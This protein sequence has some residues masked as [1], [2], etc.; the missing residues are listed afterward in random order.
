MN[1]KCVILKLQYFS[2]GLQF[3]SYIVKCRAVYLVATGSF[4]VNIFGK[5]LN[6]S[7]VHLYEKKHRVVFIRIINICFSL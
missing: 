4:S 1:I 3:N 7:N 2:K 6:D 5:S